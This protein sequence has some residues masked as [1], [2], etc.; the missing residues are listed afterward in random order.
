MLKCPRCKSIDR[1]SSH[2]V[3]WDVHPFQR[4][5]MGD[6]VCTPVC[7]SCMAELAAQA[8]GYKIAVYTK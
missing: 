8:R 2:S 6:Q 1:L 3:W 4:K 7:G 5:R